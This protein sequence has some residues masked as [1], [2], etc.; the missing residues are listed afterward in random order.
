VLGVFGGFGVSAIIAVI[1][2]YENKDNK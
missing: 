1:N 2:Y